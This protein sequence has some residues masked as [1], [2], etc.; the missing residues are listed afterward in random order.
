MENQ[1]LLKGFAGLAGIAFVV[2]LVQMIKPFVKDTR[3]YPL[4][5]VVLGIGINLMIGWAI[6]L[7]GKVGFISAC[8]DGIVV[9]LAASGIYSARDTAKLIKKR[10]KPD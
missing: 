3:F 8:F 4:I 2:A 9:G 6:G 5:A 1:E 7:G 10:R